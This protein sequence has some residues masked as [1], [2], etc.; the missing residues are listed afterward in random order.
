MGCKRPG[1]AWPA[2]LSCVGGMNLAG[3]LL[4]LIRARRRSGVRPPPR[5][6]PPTRTHSTDTRDP[7][8][9]SLLCNLIQSADL[10][11]PGTRNKSQKEKKKSDQ[12]KCTQ[13]LEPPA[14]SIRAQTHDTRSSRAFGFRL[15]HKARS[16]GY[17]FFPPLSLPFTFAA[18]HRVSWLTEW[19]AGC[20]LACFPVL[21]FC[22]HL[23]H[24]HVDADDH[25][26]MRAHKQHLACMHGDSAAMG[27]FFPLDNG[28]STRC[29]AH[30]RRQHGT[31][32]RPKSTFRCPRR[33]PAPPTGCA[34][35]QLTATLSCPTGNEEDFG[36]GHECVRPHVSP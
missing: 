29:N 25:D 30:F 9:S 17:Y 28:D 14:S 11:H 15:K 21:D 4:P 27:R 7:E 1:G 31:H 12:E 35:L 8:K 10:V 26:D 20:W 32:R 3:S 22:A 24:G 18:C 23:A 19:L 6:F 34:L 16:S 13:P 33:L 5:M 2:G 36:P